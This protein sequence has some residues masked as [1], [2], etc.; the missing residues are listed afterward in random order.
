M[1]FTSRLVAVLLAW[2]ACA[3]AWA[4]LTASLE[5]NQIGMGDTVRL[6]LQSDDN[7]PG[8]PDIRPLSRDFD[9][10]GSSSGSS[11]QIVN[12]RSASL[13]QLSLLVS[14]KHPGMLQIPPL[15]WGPLQSAPLQLAVT[16]GPSGNNNGNANNGA[17]PESAA[18]V[19]LTATPDQSRPY[20]QGAVV[21]TV[22]LYVGTRIEQ[23]GLNLPGN[24]DVSVKQLGS[25]SQSSEVR[26]GRAYQVVQRTYLLIP[27]RSGKI[28]LDGPVLDAQ[29]QDPNGADPFGPNGFFGNVFPNMPLSRMMRSLRPL[30]LA[31]DS[32]QLE[33]L[34][35]P[36]GAGGAQWLPAQNLK[37]EERWSPADGAIRAGEPLT[38]HLHLSATGVAGTQLPDLGAMMVMPEGIKSYPDQAKTSESLQGNMLLG[39]R[40]QDIALIAAKA[41]HYTLPALRLSWWDTAQQVQREAELPARSIDILPAAAAAGAGAPAATAPAGNDAGPAAA[42]DG[43]AGAAAPAAMLANMGNMAAWQWISAAMAL[44]WLATLLAWWLTRRIARTPGAAAQ[45]KERAEPV[46]VKDGGLASPAAVSGAAALAALQQACRDQDAQAARRHVLAWAAGFWPDSPP[47]GLNAVALRLADPRFSVPLRELDRACYAGAAWQGE[48]LAQ[49]FAA[50]PRQAA[51]Q[52]ARAVLPDLYS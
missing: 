6:L 30:H 29:V 11:F 14:P 33:V 46:L 42:P 52:T 15:Q 7:P 9:V 41:G 23:A 40:D 27:Q 12:G 31:G 48:A 50:P 44:L 51:A 35:R 8:Q 16:A 3:S 19:F 43:Q 22:R 17:A 37:L 49:A 24:A 38:R 4:G 28:S 21:L 10:L 25:D 18:P 13:K 39:S 34:P 47:R 36:A 2:G 32:I 1:T 45:L 20:V 26:N 5:K